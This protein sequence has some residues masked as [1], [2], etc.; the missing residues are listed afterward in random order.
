MIAIILRAQIKMLQ[1]LAATETEK[2]YGLNCFRVS[3]VA[4]H[5]LMPLSDYF[6]FDGAK[7]A[8]ATDSA[9]PAFGVEGANSGTTRVFGDLCVQ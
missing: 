9:L 4:E 5:R 3:V 2:S 8:D 6:S 1:A 7:T